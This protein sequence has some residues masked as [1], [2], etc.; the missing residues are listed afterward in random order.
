M[1]GI[2]YIME[3]IKILIKYSEEL[4]LQRVLQTK[5]RLKWYFDNGYNLSN[6]VLPQNIS[7]EE[8]SKKSEDEIAEY[9]SKE[10]DSEVFKLHI[11]IINS[12]LPNYL[13]KL[14]D[15]FSE[16]N[17]KVL[18]NI[19]IKLTKY[20][21][22]GSY[23]TPNTV[24]VNISRFFDV[25][26]IRNILHEIIHLHIQGLVDKYQIEQWEKEIVVD[27][28]FEKF[29]PDIYKKQNYKIDESRV[30]KIFKENYPNLELIMLNISKIV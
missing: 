21:T 6:S 5:E 4:E 18:P 20:G 11:Q 27:S 8:L 2:I 16:I 14:A 30:Q 22:A 24:I 25:G 26:L 23:N 28:I 7:T 9:V 12:L 1:R 10:Y 15:Y 13:N 3:K 19:E 17:I 29:F